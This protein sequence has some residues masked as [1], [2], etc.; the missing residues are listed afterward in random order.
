MPLTLLK[1][2]IVLKKHNGF[3]SAAFCSYIRTHNQYN[4]IY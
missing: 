3:C 1:A 2:V 4:Y